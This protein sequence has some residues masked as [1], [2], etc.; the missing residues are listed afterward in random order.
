MRHCQNVNNLRTL[1]QM[2]QNLSPA[3]IGPLAAFAYSWT[4][5]YI[6]ALENVKSGK[7]HISE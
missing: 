2:G 6:K 3:T 4:I 5:C 7:Y 1:A